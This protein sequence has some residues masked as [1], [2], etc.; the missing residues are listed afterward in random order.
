MALPAVTGREGRVNIRFEKLRVLRRMRVV[1]AGAL[2]RRG[3]DAEM[4]SREGRAFQVM[5]I[6][7]QGIQALIEQCAIQ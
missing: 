6:A 3:C 4:G 7:A 5:A 1:A 2:H